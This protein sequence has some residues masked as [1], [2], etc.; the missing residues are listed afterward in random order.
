MTDASASQPFK[1]LL[2]AENAERA[3]QVQ[4][5]LAAAAVER[6]D[7]RTAESLQSGIKV[8]AKN[9]FDAVILDLADKPDS[10]TEHVEAV[11]KEAGEG[12]V[13][14]LL[15]DTDLHLLREL[16]RK[17]VQDYLT[18]DQLHQP[19]LWPAVLFAIERKRLERSIFRK[20]LQDH[21]HAEEAL[22]QSEERY[23]TILDEIQDGYFEVTLKGHFTFVN[24]AFCKITGYSDEEAYGASFFDYTDAE[25]AK[26]VFGCYNKVFETGLPNPCFEYVVRRKDGNICHL[27][28]SASLIRDD[29]GNRVG[30]RGLIRDIS[31]RKQA[32]EALRQ[33]EERYRTIL[34]DIQDGYF[35][36]DAKGNLIFFNDSFREWVGLGEEELKGK[37]YSQFLDAAGADKVFEAFNR[38]YTSGIGD[39]NVPLQ[40]RTRKG[41]R[42][43]ETFISL[44]RDAAGKKLGFRGLTRDITE[45]RQAEEALRQSEE[46]YRNILEN[47]QDGYFEVDL[48][49]NLTFFNDSF[50]KWLGYSREELLGLNNRQ[51]MDAFSSGEVYEAFNRIYTTG[52]ADRG[53]AFQALTKS[54]Q[55]HV[56]ASV[57]LMMDAAGR[58]V[59]FRG[60][61]R[62][63][64]N[65][66]QAEE[67]LRQSEERYR[68]I[69]DNIQDGYF[70]VD[71][72]GNFNFFNEAFC[73]ITDYT[74]EELKDFHFSRFIDQKTV[75]V[76]YDAYHHIYETGEPNLSLGYLIVRKDGGYRHLETSV[77]LIKDASGRRI[78]FRGLGRDITERKAADEALRQ[79]EERYRTILESIED[80]YYEVDLK[81]NMVFFNESLG[82]Q[83]GYSG[84]EL[85]GMNNRRF[86][87]AASAKKIFEVFNRIYHTGISESGIE[88]L[89]QTKGGSQRYMETSVSL[90][91]DAAGNKTGFRGITRDITERKQAEEALRQS[92]ERYRTILESIEDAYFESDLKGHL[93]FF[94]DALGRLLGYSLK[95]LK[96]MNNRQ[97]TDTANA[98][99]LYA[100]F[101]KVYKTG[102]P[103]SGIEYQIITKKGEVRYTESSSSLIRDAEGQGIGFRGIMRD[104]TLRKK[105]ETELQQAKDAAEAATRAKSEF[106]ANM[107]HEIRTP[108]NGIIGMYNLLLS[109]RLDAEQVDYV[110]TGKR[111]AD[112]LL[113]IINDILDFS[114]IE[115]GKLDLEM[116]DFDLRRAMEEVVE[117][118]AMQAHQK[119]LEFAY[120][121][122]SD[123]PSL[124]KGDPGRLRQIITNLS[125]NA[126]K[127][128]KIGEVVL[129]VT[130]VEETDRRIKIRFAVQDTGIGISEKD[131]ERLFKSFHQVDA[132]T[133]RKYGGTGL[134]LAISKKLAEMM[135]GEIG[136]ESQ[137]GL[138][139]TFWF[140][141][142]FDK[143]P[144]LPEKDFLLPESIRNKRILV[145]DDNKTNLEILTGYL[146]AWGC[147]CDAARDGEM[148]LSMMHAVAKVGA[149]F[150]LVITDMR[151]PE[152]DGAEL[153]RRIKTDPEL[154]DTLII[155]LTSQGLR[156]DASAM[157]EIG[158]SAYLTKP[159]RRSQLFD[160]LAMVLGIRKKA[161]A[162]K[163]PIITKHSIV[164]EKRKR[165]RILLAEDNTVNRKLAMHLLEKFGFQVDAVANGLEAVNALEIAPY[166]LVLMDVQMPE[167]DGLEA[168]RAIRDPKSAVR[169]RQI[170]IIAM[171]AHAMKGDR[172]MC[173]RSGMDDYVSKPIQPEQLFSAIQRQIQGP[174]KDESVKDLLK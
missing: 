154:K 69:L 137:M 28:T 152:M 2:V 105:A 124:L 104:V 15:A 92:E 125:A 129:R 116:L 149:L 51:Y 133:T 32:Q 40:A 68:N 16:A 80:G 33:S 36:V 12:A 86:M 23:R 19:S 153:G 77:S 167:M 31:A 45:R 58:K 25:T 87:D 156:G 22:R 168:T 11:L 162:Q 96:G 66:K 143:Q 146:A 97:Y 17:G 30:F 3:A 98:R 102:K 6:S 10:L 43:I 21:Q 173:L 115:A 171:T 34:E 18:Q 118:P 62:D 169:D 139:S 140:T 29:Q 144:R 42:Y 135:G 49:G 108:M 163:Q 111:S 90:I 126:I 47:I 165:I 101:N 138:G 60:L 110:E 46:R 161:K 128:T 41:Y 141:A 27:E 24:N 103:N 50:H 174:K 64:T 74:R 150:D 157:K 56:E 112:S 109:T 63:I 134:G 73:R 26:M 117:L 53:I 71:L 38:V 72:K 88:Y 39:R 159:I 83:L 114:K 70:E 81:G 147:S 59:G 122:H 123:I 106:L 75:Q 52:V 142:C 1:I 79:S 65:R 57:S 4:T 55:R 93:V 121:I 164:D 84:E 107:S 14:T 166:D 8:L 89:W 158:F 78:G 91:K 119:G 160:C 20:K 131:Q 120:Q 48:K 85:M 151:M 5:V 9:A 95:E 44:I 7:I 67:A 54:G 130:P 100:A 82:R 155:M 136:V 61:A 94:N 13:I 76:I 99:K 172:E 35:E 145:V 127:F 132:S 113:T 170:P 148:A 37:N